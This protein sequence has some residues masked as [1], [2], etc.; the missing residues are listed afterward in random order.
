MR[1][2]N[3]ITLLL[4]AVLVSPALGQTLR[5]DSWKIIGPG[6]G[7]TMIAPTISPHDPHL[8]VEHCDMTAGYI[9]HDD[10]LSWRMFNLRSGIETLAFDP[11]DKNVIYAG[12][13]ALWR[14]ENRGQSWSMV[15]PNPHQNT[16]EH[17]VGDH[18]DVFLTSD[19][20]AY[21][22]AGD[23]SAI[24]IHP[25]DPHRIYIAFTKTHSTSAVYASADHGVS[26]KRLAPI[27]QSALLL[28]FD[29]DRL[30]VVAGNG[31]YAIGTDGKEAELGHLPGNISAVTAAHSGNATWIYAT[32]DKG[33]AFVSADGGQNWREITPSLGLSPA[34]FHAIASSDQHANVAY[35]GFEG[36]R[37][38]PGNS[39]LF[40]GI[41]KTQD[42]GK[43]WKIVFKESNKPAQNLDGT[44]IE[45]RAR[46]NGESIFFVAPWSLGVAPTDP[47]I[48]YATDLF[49][50]Y[51]TL[52]GGTTWKEVDSRRVD[53][54]QWTTRGLDV[55]TA[56]G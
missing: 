29:R 12:N 19:D 38:G 3:G 49:R 23:I 48:C 21:P 16:V 7:G 50:T 31:A 56:Y 2:M 25:R 18:S 30:I 52:D 5:F 53:G 35:I 28:T 17:Q 37:L 14:S 54:D 15:F 55:T 39:N 6:G 43:N 41:A 20:A 33:K 51:R 13:V 1:R 22:G 45:Q 47:D 11:S 26:W 46:Q 40:D 34:K 44:W 42:A 32:T 36:V 24:A 9:T 27:P 10:G 8:V 4:L